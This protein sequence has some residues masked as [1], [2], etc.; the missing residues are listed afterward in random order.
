MSEFGFQALPP[1]KTIATYA[2]P[3]DWNMTSYIMEHHQRSGSGNGLMIAQMT[4]TFRMPR[5]FPSLVYLSLILQAEGIRYGVEHWRRNRNRVSGTL[6]WQLNDCW[7]VLSW[8]VMDYYGFGKAG[9]YYTKRVYASVLAS[10]KLHDDGKVELWLTNDT[11]QAITTTVTVALRTFTGE[12]VWAETTPVTIAANDSQPVLRWDADRFTDRAAH[13]LSV[14][15]NDDVFPRNRAFFGMIKDVKR[16]PVKPT[17]QIAQINDHELRATLTAPA[18]AYFVHF[19]VANETV[20]FSDNYFDL[21]SGETK[22]VTITDA[23]HPLRPTD[24]TLAFR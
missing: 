14:A 9:Y 22:V 5:H 8:S 13:Y 15:S 7:P 12:T 20:Q 11:L 4:D 23:Q 19:K 2:D 18:F 24:I 3:A 10:F 1:L 6:I 17:V 21:E 16:S